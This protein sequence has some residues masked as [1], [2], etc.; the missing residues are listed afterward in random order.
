MVD[1]QWS[2][3]SATLLPLP[4]GTEGWVLR[5]VVLV[6]TTCYLLLKVHGRQ[7]TVHRLR[8]AVAATLS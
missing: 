5:D 7:S 8:D 3:V 1:G 4:E 2:E 6:L